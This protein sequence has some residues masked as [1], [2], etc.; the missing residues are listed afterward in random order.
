LLLPGDR[1]RVLGRA[2][3]ELDPTVPPAGLRT[4]SSILHFRGSTE[5]RTVVAGAVE[6]RLGRAPRGD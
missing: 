1:V 6:R 4:P 2:F 3:E 5:E